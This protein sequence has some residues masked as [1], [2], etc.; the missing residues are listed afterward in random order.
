VRL[1]TSGAQVLLLLREHLTLPT[2][3]IW[4]VVSV[5]AKK[6]R[7]C[8]G[9]VFNRVKQVADKSQKER[10][11]RGATECVFQ[12][13]LHPDI[14]RDLFTEN[15]LSRVKKNGVPEIDHS[16]FS[17]SKS[18]MAVKKRRLEARSCFWTE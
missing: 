2:C 4:A 13:D 3:A 17:P 8:R 5:I 9:G 12:A 7:R 1:K 18:G 11:A 6:K 14:G 10:L 16:A 15:L